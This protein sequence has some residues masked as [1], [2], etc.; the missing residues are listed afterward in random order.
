[1][2]VIYF[3]NAATMKPS[4]DAMRRLSSVQSSR[5]GNPHALEPEEIDA[6][7][8]LEFCKK[9]IAR[10]LDCLA[11]S[12]FFTSCASESNSQA[13][14]TALAY[15]VKCKKNHIVTTAIEHP[16][17]LLYMKHLESLG[18]E[19]SYAMP[20]KNGNVP[21][22]HVTSLIRDDTFFVSVMLVNNETGA[23]Q[24]V[25]AIAEYCRKKSILFHTDATQGAG[26]PQISYMGVS[27][28]DFVSLS[29]HKIGAGMGA[30]LLY[31][32]QD[33]RRKIGRSSP[34]PLIFGRQQ[35]G[36]RGG[37]INAPA[38]T[39]FTE[40]YKNLRAT[41]GEKIDKVDK[42]EQAL[43]AKMSEK[44]KFK[45]NCEV[46]RKPGILSVR[47]ENLIAEHLVSFCR[48]NDIS[49]SS[50]AACHTGSPEPSHVL[51]AMGLSD[52]EARRTVRI[53]LSWENTLCEIDKFIGVLCKFNDLYA[54]HL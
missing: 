31:M 14:T 22:E 1:M 18:Y 3:N 26:L 38:I 34:V 42:L 11:S 20:N 6:S 49:I 29:G 50:G 17:I 46:Y 51:K 35:K 23:K 36:A 7:Q 53:S 9:D 37:T 4:E 2:G 15:G 32:S 21:V 47:F 48:A 43:I 33:A 39:A 40:E 10:T 25:E 5:W 30:G 16:S 24:D 52:D 27:H 12:I 28:I 54:K 44:V 41:I 13:I 19:V 45:L 8:C